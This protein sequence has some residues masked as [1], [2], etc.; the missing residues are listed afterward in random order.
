MRARRTENTNVV[1]HLRGGTEDND[2]WSYYCVD[3]HDNPLIATVWVPTDEERK[4]IAEGWNIRLFVMGRRTPPVMM[5]I[6]NERI[7]K[8]HNDEPKD[9]GSDMAG[10]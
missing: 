7:G 3:E 5:D 8:P 1:H 2:L 4:K 9:A 6:T 10:S